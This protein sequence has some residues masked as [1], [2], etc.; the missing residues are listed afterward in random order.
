MLTGAIPRICATSLW[1][2]SADS[3]EVS[4]EEVLSEAESAEV[5]E[6]SLSVTALTD[7]GRLMLGQLGRMCPSLPQW[8]QVCLAA[9]SAFLCASFPLLFFLSKSGLQQQL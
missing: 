1:R 5:T 7:E 8:W 3:E 4:A 6:P 9:Q 2:E